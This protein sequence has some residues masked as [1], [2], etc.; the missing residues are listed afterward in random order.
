MNCK[1]H[2]HILC[3]SPLLFYAASSSHVLLRACSYADSAPAAPFS[4]PSL[5]LYGL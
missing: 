4:S 3:G 5:S 1:L 2:P